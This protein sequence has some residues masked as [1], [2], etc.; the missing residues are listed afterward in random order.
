MRNNYPE[1]YKGPKA[2]GSSDEEWLA[3][4]EFQAFKFMRDFTWHYSDFNCWLAVRND[5][6][7]KLGS[8]AAENVLK[9]F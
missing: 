3:V 4:T 8:K 2:G 9:E 6:H 1:D 5:W 7:Y